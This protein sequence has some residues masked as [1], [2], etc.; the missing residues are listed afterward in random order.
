MELDINQVIEIYKRKIA[1]LTHANVLLE[2]QLQSLKK[3]I[4][5]LKEE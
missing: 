4:E 1:D 3:E 2:A 5:Q